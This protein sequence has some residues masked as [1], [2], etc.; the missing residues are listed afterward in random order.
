MHKNSFKKVVPR[1]PENMSTTVSGIVNSTVGLLCNKLR[2][3]TAQRF[4][5][6][7]IIDCQCRQI[8]VR[9]LDDIKT[10]LAGL[11][12]KD[13]LAS[14]NFFTEGITDLYISLETYGESCENSSTSQA[15][16]EDDESEGATAMTVKEVEDDAIDATSDLHKFIPN[17]RMASKKYYQSAKKSFEK[18]RKLA[19][20]AFY[21]TAL[22]AEDRVM[23]SKLRIA[24][25]I[26]GCLDDPEAA[27]HDCLLYLKELQDLPAVQAMFTVW[28]EK[29]ITSRLRARLTQRNRNVTVESIQAITG[30]LLNLTLQH[31]NMRTDCLNWPTINIGKEIYHPVQHQ[32]EIM[33]KQYVQQDPW[34]FETEIIYRHCA[35][36]STEKIL[37]K[38]LSKDSLKISNPKW[39]CSM[40]CT[41]PSENNGDILNII[42]CFAVD[43][44]DNVYIVIEIHSR[45]KNVPTQYKLL[46]FDENGNPIAN[47]ALDII[48]K[49]CSPQMTVTKNGKLVIYCDRIK[50]M[51]ICD[52]TNA[53]KDCKFPL[54]LKN[55]HPNDIKE[56]SFTVSDQKEIIYTFS[57]HSDD[58]SFTMHIV[59]MGG[60]LKHEAQAPAIIDWL[61]SINVVFNHGNKTILVSLFNYNDYSSKCQ[62]YSFPDILLFSFSKAGELLY[63]FKIP[64]W[65]DHQLTSH[66]NGPIALVNKCRVIMLQM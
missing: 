53:E 29:R 15:H 24:S 21:N 50:S 32:K 23:A 11:S 12:R 7:G 63:E 41:I 37:S 16:T 64:R 3:Y 4:N 54:P 14:L 5:Q 42:C 33:K 66:P 30:L 26:L 55:V 17:L 40:F 22:S 48:E 59:T 28:R 35:V 2:D 9:N 61:F 36:T 44:N 51:Y 65:T 18:A 13:L 52:S 47:R 1:Q 31:T 46:K 27:I 20:E 39:K 58:K 34:W 60:K 19:M 25:R 57:T 45:R 10:K 38:T 6:G 49:L 56:L 8:I 43:E 62:C